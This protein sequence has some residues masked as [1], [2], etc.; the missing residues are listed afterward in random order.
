MGAGANYCAVVVDRLGDVLAALYTQAA[1][2]TAREAHMRAFG[3]W[4]TSQHL[5]TAHLNLRLGSLLQRVGEQ[6]VVHGGGAAY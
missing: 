3:A 6:R 1:V 4:G 5:R 2:R